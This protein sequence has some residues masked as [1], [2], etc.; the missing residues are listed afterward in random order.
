[1]KTIRSATRLRAAF[2]RT[3]FALFAAA[4][5]ALASC[6]KEEEEPV[7]KTDTELK[8]E[9][10]QSLLDKYKFTDVIVY[11]LGDK[12]EYSKFTIDGAYMTL[13]SSFGTVDGYIS[14][15]LLAK[16]EVRETGYDDRTYIYF[17]Y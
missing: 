7:K 11:G 6:A 16:W 4:L 17:Y 1:M 8:A 3:F 12:D 9:Q 14:I 13:Y 2:M 5:L 15:A 10:L